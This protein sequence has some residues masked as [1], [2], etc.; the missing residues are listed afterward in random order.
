MPVDEH[1]LVV[2][3]LPAVDAV[4][5]LDPPARRELSLAVLHDAEPLLAATALIALTQVRSAARADH[6]A[7]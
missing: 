5:P 7:V 3:A 1:G 2:E 4:L 6:Q